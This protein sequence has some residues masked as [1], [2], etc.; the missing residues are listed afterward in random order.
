MRSVEREA[1]DECWQE[2]VVVVEDMNR[3]IYISRSWHTPVCVHRTW[4]VLA[5]LS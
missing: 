3:K 1:L 5:M 4:A 2:V